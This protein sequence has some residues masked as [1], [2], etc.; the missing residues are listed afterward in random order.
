MEYKEYNRLYKLI[1]DI[2]CDSNQSTFF[3]FL[4]YFLVI[5]QSPV[6]VSLMNL[7]SIDLK[8]CKFGALYVERAM[9][10][11]VLV[12]ATEDA[13]NDGKETSCM[14]RVIGDYD[15]QGRI[16]PRKG[17]QTNNVLLMYNNKHRH[18]GPDMYI[19]QG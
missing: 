15:D 5:G 6:T 12:L 2:C 9:G 11:L 10:R 3:R 1:C 4:H 7:T 19:Y 18:Y 17:A 16:V 14:M 8:D 13:K